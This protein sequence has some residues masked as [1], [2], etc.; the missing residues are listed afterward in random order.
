MPSKAR[1]HSASGARSAQAAPALP[2][3]RT[4]G[5]APVQGLTTGG[6]LHASGNGGDGG[7]SA[8]AQDPVGDGTRVVLERS[9]ALR[10]A[11]EVCV[12]CGGGLARCPAYPR[13]LPLPLL[14]CA[15]PCWL[16]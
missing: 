7:D 12:R 16:L 11:L 5:G 1:P 14:L 9:A 13:F 4:S 6:G 3:A 10:V 2:F 8:A 15:Y